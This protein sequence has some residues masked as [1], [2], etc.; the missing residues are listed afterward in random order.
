[1]SVLSA[2]A[3]ELVL[4]PVE[5]PDRLKAPRVAP[6]IFSE[7]VRNT[8]SA[9]AFASLSSVWAEMRIGLAQSVII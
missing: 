8:W 7:K 2:L 6:E 3:R 4:V 1:M 9:F 5:S